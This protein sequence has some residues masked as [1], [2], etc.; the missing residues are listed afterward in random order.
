MKKP[1]PGAGGERNHVANGRAGG[2]GAARAEDYLARKLEPKCTRPGCDQPPAEDTQ[3]CSRHLA[4]ARRAS[5]LSHRRRRRQRRDAGRCACGCGLKSATWYAPACAIRLNRI[6]ASAVNPDVNHQ[7][8]Q[9]APDRWRRDNDGWQR[10]RG[11]SRRGNPPAGAKDDADLDEMLKLIERAR[12]SYQ[13]ARSAEVAKL[14][15]IQ[16]QAAV[17]EADAIVALIARF[18]DGV[19]TRHG[20]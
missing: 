3:L 2:R 8:D 14:G 5:R 9:G 15:T 20:K 17:D 6:P 18:A 4:K 1:L 12:V 13:Y 19:L 7:P 11:R 10:F 16:R